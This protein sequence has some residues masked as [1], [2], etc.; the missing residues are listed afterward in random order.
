MMKI[1]VKDGTTETDLL[2]LGVYILALLL[3]F[4]ALFVRGKS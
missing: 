1:G 4:D 3:L 2:S